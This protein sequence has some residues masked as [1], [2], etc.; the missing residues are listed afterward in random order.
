MPDHEDAGAVDEIATPQASGF[1]G[2]AVQPFET[3]IA[4]PFWRARDMAGEEFKG[5]ATTDRNACALAREHRLECD[6]FLLR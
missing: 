6:H 3:L 5:R 1:A 4:H 2:E